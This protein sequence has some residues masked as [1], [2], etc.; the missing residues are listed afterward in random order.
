VRP[1]VSHRDYVE[2]L[3]SAEGFSKE[4]LLKFADSVPPVTQ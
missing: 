3:I 1:W 2:Y 4:K